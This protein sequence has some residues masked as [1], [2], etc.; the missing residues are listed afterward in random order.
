MIVSWTSGS[1]KEPDHIRLKFDSVTLPSINYQNM[2]GCNGWDESLVKEDSTIRLAFWSFTMFDKSRCIY[3]KLSKA[4]QV[5]VSAFG[6]QI[7][8]IVEKGT[9]G[10]PD[11]DY[12]KAIAF[13]IQVNSPFILS[14]PASGDHYCI[15]AEDGTPVVHLAVEGNC[16]QSEHGPI[17]RLSAASKVRA[18]L[19]DMSLDAISK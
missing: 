5:V 13:R 19:K 16:Q 18:L 15:N 1:E 14:S 11:A 4:D 2:R 3:N 7:Y 6:N 8:N 9:E 17:E 12:W 10:A